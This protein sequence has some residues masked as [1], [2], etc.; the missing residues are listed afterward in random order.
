M[1]L[2]KTASAPSSTQAPASP[3]EKPLVLAL[4][5]GW[6]HTKLSRRGADGALSYMSFPSLAPRHVDFGM[7]SQVLGRRNTKVVYVDGTAYEIGPDSSD[8]DSGEATRNLNEQYILTEQYRAVF[9]G[10]LAYMTEN[11]STKVIDLLVGGLPLSNMRMAPKLTEMMA[12]TH[13]IAPGVS[14]TVKKALVVPQP[15]G[16]YMFCKSLS[17]IVPNFEFL[18]EENVLVIDPGYLTFDYLVVNS[19]RIVENR[20]GAHTGGV[21]KVLRSVADSISEAFDINYTNLAA[22]EKG[23]ARSPAKIKINGKTELL[24]GHVRNARAVIEGAV[25][26]MKNIVGDGSDIDTIIL[27]GGGGGIY[28]KTL[29]MFYPQHNILTV[30]SPALAN[31]MGF[32]LIGEK[33][34]R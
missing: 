23:L 8:L 29:D 18:E 17:E 30:D 19:G 2:P 24:E 1:S 9:Y 21:S 7:E 32:Q 11:E 14:V 15:L 13:E 12:G 33:A 25:T 3:Q 6:G 31:V 10:A 5:L 22:I 4:D 20:S 28:Q 27:L 26:Y 16:G 34:L